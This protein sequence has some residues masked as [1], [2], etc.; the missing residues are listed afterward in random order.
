MAPAPKARVPKGYV[1]EN[2]E[3]ATV[4]TTDQ[5]ID[6]ADDNVNTPASPTK[7]RPSGNDRTGSLEL[8]PRTTLKRRGSHGT[9]GNTVQVRANAND[10]REHLKHLILRVAPKLFG[11]IWLRSNQAR[12]RI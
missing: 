12:L 5:L 11:L 6:L 10:I 1:V 7:R 9:D 4:H 2:P 3:N 8:S